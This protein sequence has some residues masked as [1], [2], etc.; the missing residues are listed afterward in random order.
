MEMRKKRVTGV[1]ATPFENMIEM[2]ERIGQVQFGTRNFKR[3]VNHNDNK[4]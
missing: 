1:T 4:V 2:Q 3:F